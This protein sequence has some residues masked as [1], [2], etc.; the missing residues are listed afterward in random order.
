M[1]PLPPAHTGESGLHEAHSGTTRRD[2]TVQ[3]L[4]FPEVSKRRADWRRLS[5]GLGDFLEDV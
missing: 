5:D 2:C 4:V 3:K 1:E